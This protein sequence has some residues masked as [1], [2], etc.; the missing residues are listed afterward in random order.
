MNAM[1]ERDVRGFPM[2]GAD[3]DRDPAVT[4]VQ[5]RLPHHDDPQ[6]ADRAANRHRVAHDLVR[7]RTKTQRQPTAHN[8]SMRVR[9]P[10]RKALTSRAPDLACGKPVENVSGSRTRSSSYVLANR[11]RARRQRQKERLCLRDSKD[12]VLLVVVGPVENSRNWPLLPGGQ[13][14]NPVEKLWKSCGKAVESWYARPCRS[15]T[16]VQKHAF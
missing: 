8:D 1:L 4:P 7:L 16:Y 11:S 15:T 9:R 6:A 13:R 14:V 5:V 12:S 2:P 10:T 3:L